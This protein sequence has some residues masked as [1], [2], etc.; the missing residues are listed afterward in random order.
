M[1]LVEINYFIHPW[2]DYRVFVNISY[3]INPWIVYHGVGKVI[4]RGTIQ[5]YFLREYTMRLL[6]WYHDYDVNFLWNKVMHRYAIFALD[7]I[8]KNIHL[9]MGND[10]KFSY[11]TSFLWKKR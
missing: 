2:V 4:D 1:V 5:L 6:L 10:N 7:F 9:Y 11:P 8:G 3:F